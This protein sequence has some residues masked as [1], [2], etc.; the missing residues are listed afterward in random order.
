MAI[1]FKDVKI[2]GS[3]NKL[4]FNIEI[5]KTYGLI[6]NSGS[7]KTKI[8]ELICGLEIIESGQV[9]ILG[10]TLSGGSNE[11]DFFK[12]RKNIG[13][14]FENPSEQFF[15]E[16]VYDEIS[17]AL[18]NFNYKKDDIDNH[19]KKAIKLVGLDEKY[20]DRNPFT[21]SCGEAKKVALASILV[22]NP[23]IILL[24]DPTIGLDF[25]AKADLLKLLR[26]LKKRYNKTI[27]IASKDIDFIHKIVDHVLV[28]DQ[29]KVVLSGTKYNV[30]SNQKIL[31][32]IGI[33]APKLILFSDIVKKEKNINLGYRD[34]IND[35]MKDVY[36]YVK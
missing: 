33:N 12:V 1:K 36:R 23:K 31:K 35:L 34:D 18:K 32:R 5:S 30:F 8:L 21:L 25:K 22:Y 27:I 2:K 13:Y 4:N 17:F 9:E 26:V 7:N 15:Q 11:K 19:V 28:I 24:D 16:T 14:L 20:L 10:D 3:K 6:G 29:D